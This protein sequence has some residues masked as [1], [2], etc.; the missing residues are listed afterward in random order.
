MAYDTLISSNEQILDL[1]KESATSRGKSHEMIELQM[2][3]EKKK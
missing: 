2:Q 1:L 3:N